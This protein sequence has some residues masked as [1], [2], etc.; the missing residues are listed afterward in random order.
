MPTA[1]VAFRDEMI[2]LAR[3]SAEVGW[4]ELRRGVDQYDA[5]TRAGDPPAPRPHRPQRV[6]L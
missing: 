5:L 1:Q 3:E 2:A 6:K 4:R